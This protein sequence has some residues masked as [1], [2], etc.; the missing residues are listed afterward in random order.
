MADSTNKAGL[1]QLPELGNRGER[2]EAPRLRVVEIFGV[3]DCNPFLFSAL[4]QCQQG[5][6]SILPL[7]IGNPIAQMAEEFSYQELLALFLGPVDSGHCLQKPFCQGL[8]SDFN[9]D[10]SMRNPPTVRPGYACFQ[11]IGSFGM[12]QQRFVALVRKSWLI[13][14]EF[15]DL[16]YERKGFIALLAPAYMW[17]NGRR[18]KRYRP[19]LYAAIGALGVASQRC[20]I[21]PDG[22]DII[23]V[24]A[25]ALK[26]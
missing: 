3:L 8:L 25:V 9:Y 23:P 22:N 7:G 20:P 10:L 26:R 14:K 19:M 2:R 11:Y 4:A 6:W 15:A 12:T 1:H 13:Q 16:R 18:H 17:L 21:L 24:H 5:I